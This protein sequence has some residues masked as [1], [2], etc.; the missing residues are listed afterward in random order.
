M[1]GV[2]KDGIYTKSEDENQ[3]LRMGGGSWS[4]NLEELPAAATVIEYI[5]PSGKY[6]VSRQT[7]FEHGFIRVLGGERKLIVPLQWWDKDAVVIS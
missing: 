2:L 1:R 3:K 5:T 7:A 6:S 4:I